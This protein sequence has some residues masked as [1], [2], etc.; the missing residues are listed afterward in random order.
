MLKLI[1]RNLP[2]FAALLADLGS[3]KTCDLALHLG[4]SERTVWRWMQSGKAPRPAHLALF[5]VSS[6]GISLIDAEA[7]WA[8]RL[9]RQLADALRRER[10]QLAAKLA[11]LG[12]IG[13]FGSANDP[14]PEA[15]TKPLGADTAVLAAGPSC[16]TTQIARGS[17]DE[18]SLPRVRVS[19]TVA[20]DPGLAIGMP[21][22]TGR[23]VDFETASKRRA[24]GGRRGQ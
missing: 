4:V 7:E 6:W 20:V 2:S 24:G 21:T 15:P 18:T 13:E 10:D 1:P 3:P 23:P 12:Q 14:V 5:W 8:A 22:P 19:T 16:A 9:H 11:T 17:T